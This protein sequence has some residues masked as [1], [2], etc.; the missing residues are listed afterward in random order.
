M[1]Y[2]AAVMENT[3]YVC[4]RLVGFRNE[5]E[6]CI[7]NTKGAP[8]NISC[9]NSFHGADPAMRVAANAN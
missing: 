6:S 4:T 7:K 8:K 2:A 3:A 1:H 9:L 5:E